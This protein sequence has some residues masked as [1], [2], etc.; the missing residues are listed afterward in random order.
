MTKTT[1]T[2]MEYYQGVSERLVADGYLLTALELY[3]E[4]AERGKSLQSLKDFFEDSAN[5]DQFTRRPLTAAAAAATPSSSSAAAAFESP[6]PSVAGSQLTLDDGSLFDLARNS[7]DSAQQFQVSDRVAVLEFELRKANQTINSLRSEL[8]Q[9]VRKHPSSLLLPLSSPSSSTLAAP[10]APSSAAAAAQGRKSGGGG[11]SSSGEDEG[12]LKGG[13]GAEDEEEEGSL[14]LLGHEKRTLNFLVNEYLLSYGYK[15]TAITFSDENSS[16]DF[17]D[18]DSIGLNMS[19]PPDLS[20][21]YRRFLSGGGGGSSHKENTGVNSSFP[22]VISCEAKKQPEPN[23]RQDCDVQVE[24]IPSNCQ[25]ILEDLKRQLAERDSQMAQV[26]QQKE[27][28]VRRQKEELLTEAAKNSAKLEQRIKELERRAKTDDDE[29][30]SPA[31]TDEEAETG[32]A[33]VALSREMAAFRG[34]LI[35]LSSSMTSLNDEED[36]DVSGNNHLTTSHEFDDVI[37][38]ISTSLPEVIPH[39]LLARRGTVLPLMLTAIRHHRKSEE[40]DKLLHLL[41]NLTKKPDEATREVIVKGFVEIASAVK[42]SDG[43]GGGRIIET[44]LLPQLWQQIEHKYAERRVL[45]AQTCLA[46]IPHI[47]AP[48]RDSLVF[49]MLL[50]LVEQDRELIVRQTAADA[51]SVLVLYLQDDQKINLVLPKLIRETLRN[52]EELGAKIQSGLLLSFARCCAPKTLMA[53][54]EDFVVFGGGGSDLP[55]NNLAT[56]LSTLSN[57]LPFVIS[58]VIT[59]A[60]FYVRRSADDCFEADKESDENSGNRNSNIMQLLMGD[61]QE[62]LAKLDEC[63][64]SFDKWPA[65]AWLDSKV[66]DPLIELASKAPASS[67]HHQ[68]QITLNLVSI[69]REIATVFGPRFLGAKFENKMT[70]LLTDEDPDD[71]EESK[72]TDLSSTALIPAYFLGAMRGRRA[73]GH[74][75]RTT[76]LLHRAILRVCT[77][78][79]TA[80]PPPPNNDA[81]LI[82]TLSHMLVEYRHP[83]NGHLSC[84]LSPDDQQ[85]QQPISI[86]DED[87]TKSINQSAGGSESLQVSTN[88]LCEM[89][90][91]LVVHPDPA[92]KC[93]AGKTLDILASSGYCGGDDLIA[94]KILPGLVTLSSDPDLS[95][96]RAAIPGLGSVICIG[97]A[98]SASS[99][100]TGFFSMTAASGVQKTGSEKS[101]ISRVISNE[102][103]EK[104]TFQLVSKIGAGQM[105][106]VTTTL[107]HKNHEVFLEVA[108][109]IGRIVIE[110]TTRTTAT[111]TAVGSVSGNSLDDLDSMSLRDD[112]LI[113][114]LASINQLYVPSEFSDVKSLEMASTLLLLYKSIMVEFGGG[115]RGGVGLHGGG[116]HPPPPRGRAMPLTV[117]QAH[118]LPSLTKIGKDFHRMGIV[119]QETATLQLIAQL[120]AEYNNRSAV[121][122]AGTGGLT[123]LTGGGGGG[124]TVT[125][126]PS[127]EEVKNKVGK[128]FNRPAA[129]FWSKK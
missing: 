104:A 62:T 91:S 29:F 56:N 76:D 120:D 70:P 84:C 38:L 10:S 21:I 54:V 126:S 48:I 22:D 37:E 128:L 43:G 73:A 61:F 110:C 39:V 124:S 79:T 35:R 72:V 77:S 18:W 122:T 45:V 19:K 47:P 25:E 105:S 7:E 40:R 49:S 112:V 125:H 1:T 11:H 103:R 68:R 115:G 80:P 99:N 27:D 6:V 26:Q 97:L 87:E 16:E 20:R 75:A 129:S 74:G 93:F 2:S 12:S 95:V 83:T 85:Q 86:E 64:T 23:H 52:D 123:G 44:E 114:K 51:M 90:W 58:T 32:F 96:Q 17:E 94:T 82:F 109:T 111:T 60:P 108:R 30:E 113:P 46:L 116:S 28:A 50:Q 24:I 3:T 107:L 41:F 36:N 101:T 15:L 121:G 78:S 14:E 89:A 57:L 88:A 100:A 4:L 9:Q 55:T 5:F 53:F 98:G 119:A 31:K 8:T 13:M 34:F 67:L 118:V 81:G 71:G 102:T 127:M 65:L 106:E 117:Y 69:F 42:T 66:I 33:A 63:M 92:V 59:E